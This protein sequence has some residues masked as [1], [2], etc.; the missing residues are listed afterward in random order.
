MAGPTRNARPKAA[1][2]SPIFFVL[3]AGVDM[4]EIYACMTPNPAPP[5]PETHRAS[6][7]RRNQSWY[8]HMRGKSIMYD[9][10]ARASMIYPRRLIPDVNMSIRFLPYVSESLPNMSH[11]TNIPAA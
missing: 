9:E 1:P 10:S 8:P 3:V 11:H 2:M 5:N 7:K 6:I 4:S